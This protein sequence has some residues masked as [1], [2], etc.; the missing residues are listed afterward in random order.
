MDY[1]KAAYELANQNAT[2]TINPA[3]FGANPLASPAKNVESIQKA[4]DKGG[5]VHLSTPGIYLINQPLIIGDNTHLQLGNAVTIK[6]ASGTN[7]NLLINKFRIDG[8]R[9]KN[10][11]ITGGTWDYDHASQTVG[12]DLRTMSMIIQ[13]VDNLAIKDMF[14]K[15]AKKYCYLICDFTNLTVH[16]ITFD[17]H[18]DGLHMQGPARGIDIRNIKGKTGDDLVSFTIGDF[19]TYKISQ[20]DFED[21]YVDG[22]FPN[23]SLC[24]LKLAGNAPYKFKGVTA[25]NI[26]GTTI[27]NGIAVTDDTADL[28]GTN[29]EGLTLRNIK[30]APGSGSS[31][32]LLNA[33]VMRDVQIDNF[34]ANGTPNNHIKV[35]GTAVIES[36]SINN[37][38]FLSLAVHALYLDGKVK[39][40]QLNNI[41]A[42][43]SVKTAALISIYKPL[44]LLQLDN[45]RA[46]G[47]LEL[48]G[49]VSGANGSDLTA[50][51]SNVKVSNFSRGI[52]ARKNTN[53]KMR[54]VIFENL[55][56]SVISTDQVT[57]HRIEGDLEILGTGSLST[58]A[59]GAT[60][61]ANGL[62][63]KGD[64]SKLTPLAWDF[65]F[66]TNASVAGG[67]GPVMYDG[68]T[69][70]WKHL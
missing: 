61:S 51:L 39:N 33:P 20:G 49:I 45:V 26:Y 66:N 50:I 3:Y 21:I 37:S 44:E 18:S 10:I 29:V 65:M 40:L 62:G 47:G 63:I 2:G 25:E 52:S 12:G 54:A 70:T 53:I 68:T 67:A 56:T 59:T 28:V 15:N 57:T 64:V 4:L 8:V 43:M 9:N 41:Y 34:M 32:I 30:L 69:S 60:L 11:S 24:A 42:T 38:R 17:T 36:L 22:L 23:G 58:L 55:T 13:G 16:N 19:S 27:S 46:D 14:M 6:Q 7:K 5:H 35:G 31:T 1:G 48:I